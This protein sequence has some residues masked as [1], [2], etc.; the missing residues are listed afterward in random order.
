M[1]VSPEVAALQ[2]Q[3]ETLKNQQFAPTPLPPKI[4]GNPPTP[5]AQSG[6]TLDDIRSVVKGLM[7]EYAA[8][9]GTTLPKPAK[10]YTL[11]EAIGLGL[12]NDE[13]IWLSKEEIL[14]ELPN[15]IA[16]EKGQSLIKNI[17][18][19]YRSY[20]ETKEHSNNKL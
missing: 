9:L 3:I 18:S 4:I 19:E 8:T 15:F 16:S 10:R 17:I 11:L 1:V 2:A 12:T 5:A 6:I 7:D 13:Q 14:L 20:H